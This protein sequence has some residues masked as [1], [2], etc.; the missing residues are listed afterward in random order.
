MGRYDEEQTPALEVIGKFL[1]LYRY[2]R[3][4]SREMHRA[5]LR[6]KE[7]A[8]LRYL[9]ETE[10]LTIGQIAD[11]LFIS[12]S[13]TSEMISRMEDAGYV[14]RRRSE[15]DCRVVYVDLTASGEQ[16]ANE[17][18]LGGIP[19]LREKLKALPP[20]RLEAYDHCFSDLLESMEIGDS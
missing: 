17:T 19:L 20:E 15:K 16:M 3:R 5:G 7:V 8:T 9:L 13:T 11:Y 1:R 4:Y 10:P 18:P 14:A 12:T 2:F 6:G